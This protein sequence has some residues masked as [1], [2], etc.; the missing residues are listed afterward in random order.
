MWEVW[1]YEKWC[2][3]KNREGINDSNGGSHPSSKDLA[4]HVHSVGVQERVETDDFGEW[5]IV[6]RRQ[7]M[8]RREMA[9]SAFSTND[10]KGSRFNALSR[11]DEDSTRV[12]DTDSATFY[13]GQ[14]VN[15]RE[16]M[17]DMETVI[18][19]EDFVVLSRIRVTQSKGASSDKSKI[20]QIGLKLGSRSKKH[21]QSLPGSN[22]IRIGPK[23][24]GIDFF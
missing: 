19:G 4:S 1:L 21:L 2:P 16:S 10:N 9:W 13:F 15:L 5:M 7:R 8:S 12:R 20:N 23:K 6:D 18:N 22:G 17:P 14:K 3:L 11:V 24:D